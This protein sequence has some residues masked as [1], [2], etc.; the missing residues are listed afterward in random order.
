[1]RRGYRNR[2]GRSSKRALDN[3][4]TALLMGDANALTISRITAA[5]RREEL[6]ETQ[7]KVA[8]SQEKTRFL[9]VAQMRS[10]NG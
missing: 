5:E 6:Q 7:A 3:A 4:E 8:I 2:S 1:M 9:Q 10:N